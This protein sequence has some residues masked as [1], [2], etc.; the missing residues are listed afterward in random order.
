[1]RKSKQWLFGLLGVTVILG[2]VAYINRVEIALGLVSFGMDQRMQVGPNRDISVADRH[3]P[4]GP[5]ARRYDR[6]TSS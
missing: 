1:M 2:G 3:R 5:C 6:L 4:S